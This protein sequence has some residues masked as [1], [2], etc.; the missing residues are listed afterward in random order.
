[1]RRLQPFAHTKYVSL[2]LLQVATVA[3]CEDQIGASR[4]V[5]RFDV[6]Q[7]D[8][9]ARLADTHAIDSTLDANLEATDGRVPTDVD[10]SAA[11]DVQDV[12]DAGSL[13][14][15]VP[16]T[17]QAQLVFE[18]PVEATTP[19]TWNA[20]LPKLTG[21]E[22]FYYVNY[23]FAPADHTLRYSAILQRPR[24]NGPG[25]APAP[26]SEVA[27]I[28]YPH[29]P[30]GIV[31]DRARTL[32]LVFDCLQY[33]PGMDRSCFQG[34]ANSAG[35]VSR[36]YHLG[37]SAR[38]PL[39]AL[40]WDAYGNYNEWTVLSNGYMGIAV[41]PDDSVHWSLAD[42]SWARHVQRFRGGRLSPA[43]VLSEP[44]RYLLYPSTA[45]SNQSELMF[46]GEFDPG[47][48]SNAGYPAASLYSLG[49]NTA[50]RILRIT[51]DVPIAAGEV[52]AFPTDLDVAPNQTIYALSY[53]KTAL[54]TECT[55]LFRI[56][57]GGMVST[58]AMG[59]LDSY[60]RL[61]IVDD[62]TLVII[63][64]GAR[65]TVRIGVSNDRGD[66]WMWRSVPITGIA[67]QDIAVNSWTT[68][69]ETNSPLIYRSD[70][71]A[72]VFTGIQMNNTARRMY[73]AEFSLR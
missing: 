1:M 73:F 15:R 72:M 22:S 38:D 50:T 25:G 35:L 6:V 47:G 5:V 10:A 17:I 7:A 36:F 24:G 54:A 71:V 19:S 4:D 66:H 44:G 69:D 12:Q 14:I 48:G 46:V 64:S 68:I 49:V 56:L 51:P 16:P 43:P 60:A 37:F 23:T 18:A 13:Q 9:P 57:P 41:A 55:K 31:M 39:G 26:W 59:C 45:F 65:D 11:A 3:G 2:C 27:R 62:D 63:A 20:H 52:G 42:G 28:V 58:I 67:A 32:H 30:P 53:V 21:D 34:G 33:A 40:R 8:Q 70:R 29:Q 61:Q